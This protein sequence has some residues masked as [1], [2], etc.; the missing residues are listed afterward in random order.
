MFLGV[1]H[2]VNLFL[3]FLSPYPLFLTHLIKPDTCPHRTAR[4]DLNR[5][6]L[7]EGEGTIPGS[8]VMC[9]YHPA[10]GYTGVQALWHFLNS[11]NFSA[12]TP[13]Q[14]SFDHGDIPHA[15]GML[16][17]TL[18]PWEIDHS[19]FLLPATHMC[20]IPHSTSRGRH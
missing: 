8:C 15:W 12:P 17:F 5:T 13:L 9:G 1:D 14:S 18:Q 3:G 6:P 11:L 4:W 2:K 7:M 19:S 20:V 16:A 10:T